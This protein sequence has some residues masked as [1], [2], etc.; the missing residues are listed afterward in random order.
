MG[1]R[2]WLQERTGSEGFSRAILDHKA[3]RHISWAHMLGSAT[4]FALILQI[5]T[6]IL[7]SIYYVPTPD[8]AWES[9][10]YIQHEVLFGWLIR[11][12]HNFGTSALIILVGLHLIRVVIWGAY[13]Y[14]REFTWITGVL[15]LIVVMF[16][17]VTGDLLP[18]GQN[19]YWATKVRV[20]YLAGTPFIG[21]AFARFAYGGDSL[22]AV[23][24]M[25]F[26]S[27]HVLILPAALLLILGVHLYLVVRHGVAA[28]PWHK[29]DLEPESAQLESSGETQ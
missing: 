11:G 21:E 23:T 8:Y 7:L 3:P 13:K 27:L 28:A 10:N 14:P 18:W 25:R 4:L 1:L 15:L 17:A 9:V 20:G 12:I 29:E 16:F 6:G 2:H 22:S 24:L 19:S 26:Y 5:V